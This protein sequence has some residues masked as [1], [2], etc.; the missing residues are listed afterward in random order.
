MRERDLGD[1]SL[2]LNK[3]GVSSL[4]PQPRKRMGWGLEKRCLVWTCH[5]GACE[6]CKPNCPL[7]SRTFIQV[8]GSELTVETWG[9]WPQ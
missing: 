7:W 5:L 2:W 3:V 4:R 9:L 6:T 1:S 8:W